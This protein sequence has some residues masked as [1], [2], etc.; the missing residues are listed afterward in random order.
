MPR[1]FFH[2]MDGRAV[3]DT[4]GLVLN[5]DTAA[6]VEALRGAGEMLSRRGSA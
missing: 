6:R 4:V 3:I 2:V 5:D 1:Y